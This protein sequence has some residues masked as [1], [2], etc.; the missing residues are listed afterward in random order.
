MTMMRVRVGENLAAELGLA[1]LVL[2]LD[3]LAAVPAGG[4]MVKPDRAVDRM[5]VKLAHWILQVMEVKR[6][7][8]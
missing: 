7:L 1:Q 5:P 6:C 3:R 8:K 2:G 4:R